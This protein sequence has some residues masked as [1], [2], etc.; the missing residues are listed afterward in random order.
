MTLN[1]ITSLRLRIRCYRSHKK[2]VRVS[3]EMTYL[4]KHWELLNIVVEYELKERVIHHDNISFYG[5]LCFAGI[6]ERI[7]RAK[8]KV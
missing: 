7:S 5:G 6:Y 2:V 8:I 1:F 3:L 4:L